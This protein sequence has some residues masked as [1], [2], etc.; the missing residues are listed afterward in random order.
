[1]KKFIFTLILPIL[2]INNIFTQQVKPPDNLNDIVIRENTRD[3]IIIRKN[4]HHSITYQILKDQ[5][6]NKQIL[7]DRKLDFKSYRLNIMRRQIL[8]QQRIMR[9][10]ILERNTRMLNR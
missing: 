3:K 2:L 6:S 5:L 7:K 9:Q 10:R 1:M 8:R 4:N